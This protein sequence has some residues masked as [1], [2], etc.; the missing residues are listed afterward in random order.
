MFSLLWIS[1]ASGFIIVCMVYLV[2]VY[3]VLSF[4]FELSYVSVSM[5]CE[6]IV[7]MGGLVV[8]YVVM[9]LW[10]MWWSGCLVM[11]GLWICYL[12]FMVLCYE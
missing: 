6:V 12:R 11:R 3:Y 1:I 9:W 5:C 2:Y 8:V 4:N 7:G 10:D